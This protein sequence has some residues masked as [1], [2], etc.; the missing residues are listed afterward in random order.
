ME[1]GEG[2]NEELPQKRAPEVGH[3]AMFNVG[4][5]GDNASS[6]QEEYASERGLTSEEDSSRQGEGPPE[7]GKS[8]EASEAD[9]AFEEPPEIAD[10]RFKI[11]EP[12]MTEETFPAENKFIAEEALS[13]HEAIIFEQS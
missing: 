9:E 10:E 6:E 1:G 3:T 8:Y 7:S 4:L 13:S 5:D 2:T 12:R 11:E